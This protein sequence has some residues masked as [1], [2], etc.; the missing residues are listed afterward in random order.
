MAARKAKTQAGAQ[1][2]LARDLNARIVSVTEEELAHLRARAAVADRLE[3]FET[4]LRAYRDQGFFSFVDEGADLL[5]L[6][7][8]ELMLLRSDHMMPVLSADLAAVISG[9]FLTMQH[10][11]RVN[12]TNPELGAHQARYNAFCT[13]IGVVAPAVG[14]HA[15][16]E[17]LGHAVALVGSLRTGIEGIMGGV[18]QQISTPAV[19]RDLA[20]MGEQM[21]A[22]DIVL[23][24]LRALIS[25]G[26][27]GVPS[28]PREPPARD[29]RRDANAPVN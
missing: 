12:L 9:A 10:A 20:A 28:V 24:Q 23:S 1:G 5:D 7:L 3:A 14:S 16:A 4:R 15:R 6:V 29:L 11:L 18:Q 27:E 26:R 2:D 19:A 17:A 21:K 13:A 22:Y 25:G 8:N